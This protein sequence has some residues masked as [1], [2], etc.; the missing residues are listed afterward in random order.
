MNQILNKQR[1][2]FKSHQ[3][4]DIHFRKKQLITL[5]NQ[6]QLYE[7]Q[8]LEAI[9]L[10]LNK[11]YFESYETELLGVYQEIKYMLKNITTLSRKKYKKTPIIYA[12]YSC[13]EVYQPY[14]CVFIIATWNYP[15][16]LAMMPL[17]GAISAGNCCMLH[18]SNYAPNTSKIIH[19]ILNVFDEQYIYVSEGNEIDTNIL[20]DEKF[21]YIFFTGSPTTGKKVYQKAS[22][23]LTPVTLELG[24]K[25]P[26][27]VE[28]SATI[29]LA[30]KRI[31]WGKLLNAGQTCVAPDYVIVHE[32]IKQELVSKIHQYITLFYG[33]HP[34]LH[35]DYPRIINQYHFD[36]LLKLT[37]CVHNADTLSIAPTIMDANWEH[38]IM[39][40][41][42]F[43]P[44]LPILTYEHI[45][46]VI[47]KINGQESPLALYLFTSNTQI[48]NKIVNQIQYGG[49]CINDTIMHVAN[50]NLC[51]G[52]I[53]NSGIGK[54]HGTHSFMTFSHQ[55][56]ILKQSSIRDIPIRYAPYKN[57]IKL[58]KIINK[59][60]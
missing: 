43:G 42:I 52:G 20:L 10:D 9:K 15:F 13:Y 47:E 60:I 51:F 19:Q 41:E 36:R 28:E 40:E 11:S 39:K 1:N 58:L 23:H 6:I 14:G 31:V 17:I 55:K 57:K 35:K 33:E 44:I 46:E 54:Y 7:P 27:I 53:G 22:I 4:L 2:Y 59:H 34:H 49:G 8:L 30:A 25:S 18:T 21:D 50:P 29:A 3:T 48:E 38:P 45:D 12:P 26:C 37:P 24:G 16:H 5:Y 56:S 32:S